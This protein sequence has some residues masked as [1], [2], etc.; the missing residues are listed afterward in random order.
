MTRAADWPCV[1]GPVHALRLTRRAAGE[2]HRR[3]RAT[4]FKQRVTGRVEPGRV[5][6]AQLDDLDALIRRDQTAQLGFDDDELATAVVEDRGDLGGGQ[7]PVQRHQASART[8]IAEHELRPLD[9]ILRQHS[10]HVA[11]AEARPVQSP[12]K[13]TRPTLDVIPRQHTILGGHRR[14]RRVRWRQQPPRLQLSHV[15]KP[16]PRQA[17]FVRLTSSRSARFRS[18]HR[19]S[20]GTPSHRLS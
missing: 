2:H 15:G 4:L 17:T 6:L 3:T 20:R 16:L 10:P 7:V 1:L 5:L 8:N 12:S 9:S 11:L 19:R 18:C 14:G 13:T